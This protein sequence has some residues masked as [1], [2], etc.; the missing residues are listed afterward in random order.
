MALDDLSSA[1]RACS[2]SSAGGPGGVRYVQDEIAIGQHG[3]HGVH[4][5]LV[6]QVV[7]LMNTGRV[8]ENNLRVRRSQDALDG[9]ASG[10]RLVSSNGKLFADE[11]VQQ[12]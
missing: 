7:R 11:R 12:S 4:H 5:A 2:S 6:D 3:P 10:L 8:D 9:R 1:L